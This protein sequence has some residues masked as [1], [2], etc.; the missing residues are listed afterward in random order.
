MSNGEGWSDFL[1]AAMR[2]S[3]YGTAADLSRASGIDQT[4]ISRWLRGL[5]QPSLDN[6]RKLAPALRRPMLELVVASGHLTREEARLRDLRPIE[7]PE[8]PSVSEAVERDPRLMDMAREHLLRQYEMLAQLSDLVATKDTQAATPPGA[9]RPL[10][11]AARR[12]KPDR[13]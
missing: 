12:G 5:G 9:Q 3:G 11:A 2:K 8:A 13:P 10:R 7:E 6:L 4:Q 1:D